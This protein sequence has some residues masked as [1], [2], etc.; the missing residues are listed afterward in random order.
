MLCSCEFC[1][2]VSD[3]NFGAIE[4]PADFVTSG[5]RWTDAGNSS[6]G[7]TTTLGGSGGV[8]AWSLAGAGLTNATGTTFFTGSTVDMGTFL[9]YDF[10][11]V[12]RQA[13]DRW[14]Q[15]A[16]IEFI[17]VVDGGSNIGTGTTPTI[18]IVGGFIDGQSGSNVLARAFFPSTTPAGGDIVFDS[19]NTTFF[20]TANNFFLTALHEIG[21]ALGL[22]HETVNLA[23]MN[24]TINTALTGLQTDDING[25]RA[26]YG[27]QD[28]GTNSFFMPAG[29][30]SLTLIDGAPNLVVFGNAL[31]NVINGTS[32]GEAF[33]GGAGNDT[34]DGSGGTDTAL[35]SGLRSQYQ[36]IFTGGFFRIT[37]LRGGSPQG[38]DFVRNMEF[39]SFADGTIAA[40]TP[41]K[42]LREMPTW[43]SQ[44]G[45]FNGDGT[46]DLLWNNGASGVLGTWLMTNGA[47]AGSIGLDHDM[48]GW[49]SLIGDFNGDRIDDI[50]WNSGPAGVLGTWLMQ[51]GRIAATFGLNH[52]MPGWHAVVGDFNGDGVDDLLWNSGT[53]GIL[54]TWLMQGGQ[55][56]GTFG[57]NHDMPGW[58]ALAG[59][60]N[61]DGTSDLLW[62]SDS[63]GVLGVWLMRNGVIQV[64]LALNHDM[65]DFAAVAVGD[66]NK[67]GTSDI[68]WRHDNGS[69]GLWLMRDGQVNTTLDMGST[70][71]FTVQTSGDFNGDGFSDV[72]WQDG[73][74]N[75]YTWNFTTGGGLLPAGA[76]QG[77]F[78]AS[79]TVQEVNGTAGDDIIVALPGPSNLTGGA[80]SDTFIFNNSTPGDATIT[81]FDT[82]FD[83]IELAGFSGIQSFEDLLAG[84]VQTANGT[85]LHVSPTSSITLLDVQKAQLTANDFHIV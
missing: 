8:V 49:H 16:N 23:I 81:D 76:V 60:F 6:G 14:A 58:T 84:A 4:Q 29:Q 40:S 82:A 33:D 44:A 51:N 67:D 47:I 73:S 57:L 59:D 78:E 1:A 30:P 5:R 69:T 32:A 13:F 71:G 12:L 48:P 37:D 9:P 21:H 2:G 64:S 79:L 68:L 17:Q 41:F 61:G 46:A 7:T 85:L 54:G 75:I 28:F 35:Y 66:F 11:A 80:G 19:G 53:Q 20:A 36:I 31:D 50:L 34:I 70:A 26:V 77:A 3:P 42:F 18:R 39:L 55:I 63:G 74:G 52:D 83:R 27:A 15:V 72:V 65:P 38:T 43:F 45:D 10:Q 56:A 22:D 62:K 25:I 24:P